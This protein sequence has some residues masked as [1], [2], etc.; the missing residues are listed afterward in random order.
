MAA[1]LSLF[2][3]GNNNCTLLLRMVNWLQP[4]CGITRHPLQQQGIV[5][6]LLV[7]H[8]THRC[9]AADLQVI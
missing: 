3:H 4:F 6:S 5:I 9:N 1:G 7:P 8:D 2:I